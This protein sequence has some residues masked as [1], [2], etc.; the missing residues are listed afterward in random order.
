MIKISA[1]IPTKNGEKTIRAC[2]DSIFDQSVSAHMEVIVIDS[3]STDRTLDIVR[4]YPVRIYQ[5]PPEEFNHGGTRNMGVRLARG[6]FILFTVQDARLSASDVLEKALEHF[7]DAEVMA[8]GC[9]QVVPHDP[10]KNPLQ[11]YRPVNPPQVVRLHYPPGEFDRLPSEE[12]L[13]IARLDNVCAI[14][15]RKA[16]MALPFPVTDYAEDMIW[17]MQSLTRGWTIIL[18]QRLLVYHYHHYENAEKIK[19]RLKLEQ[20]LQSSIKKSIILK[21]KEFVKIFYLVFLKKNFVPSRKLYWLRYNLRLWWY[22]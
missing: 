20:K 8:V 2:L 15:R 16:L 21:I 10:D 13:K 3:G 9:K 4:Q 5:I 1:V 17:A 22:K 14:Y 12:R 6:E 7:R 11:W 19:A 18:D